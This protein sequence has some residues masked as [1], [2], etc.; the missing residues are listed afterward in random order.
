[1]GRG[2]QPLGKEKGEGIGSTILDQINFGMSCYESLSNET[3]KAWGRPLRDTMR[4][5]VIQFA[6]EVSGS[7]TE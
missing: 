5:F 1:V 2:W 7:A 3:A 4:Q 6:K